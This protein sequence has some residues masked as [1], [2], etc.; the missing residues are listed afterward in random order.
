MSDVML[1]GILR[2]P[3]HLALSAEWCRRQ[4]W[5]SGQQAAAEIERLQDE[6]ERL[7][8]EMGRLTAERTEAV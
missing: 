4:Y 6:V 7:K 2:Q 3:F 8:A 5:Q 1:L